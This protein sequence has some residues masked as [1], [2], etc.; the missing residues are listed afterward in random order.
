MIRALSNRIIVTTSWDDNSYENLKIARLLDKLEMRGTF[1]ISSNT[2]SFGRNL[3]QKQIKKM[4]LEVANGGHE[5]GSHTVNHATL[6]KCRN[7]REE[8]EDSKHQLEKLTGS[9]VNCFCYPNGAF[10]DNVKDIV[11]D[12]GYICART[13]EYEKRGLPRDPYAWGITL[14]ASNGSPRMT[15]KIWR[16]SGI[17]PKSLLD[18]E[19]RAK[20]LFDSILEKGGIWHLWGHAWEIDVHKDWSKLTRVLQYVSGREK[21]LY[22][23]NGSIFKNLAIMNTE[24][25]PEQY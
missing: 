21:V 19:V 12:T 9:E 8:I 10:N 2:D 20:L 13:C 4:V 1:Y 23:E 18:W 14:H 24:R 3:N 22:L 17:S 25:T 6:T 7:P 15:F 11:E 5:V 16:Q